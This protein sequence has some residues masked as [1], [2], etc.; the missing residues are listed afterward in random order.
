M[1]SDMNSRFVDPSPPKKPGRFRVGD[2]VRVPFG[3]ESIEATIVEDRGNLGVGGM[4]IYGICFR[5][6]DVTEERYTE[7]DEDQITLVARAAGPRS[8][9]TNSAAE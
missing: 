9:G 4:R 2:R 3:G 8:N 6:D 5:V 1:E 7:R